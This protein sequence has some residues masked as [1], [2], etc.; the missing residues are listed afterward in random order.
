[1][2]ASKW[3]TLDDLYDSFFEAVK[4]PVWHG[5]NLNAVRDSVGVGQIN[6]IEVPYCLVLKN[7]HQLSDQLKEKAD[8]FVELISDLE[9][10]GTPVKIRVDTD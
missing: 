8:N 2:D 9:R 4:A 5:R 10:E 6:G 3:K 1:M 7:Y